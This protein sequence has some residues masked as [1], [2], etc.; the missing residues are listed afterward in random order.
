M[1]WL[2]F[3][4]RFYEAQRGEKE[5]RKQREKVRYTQ[6]ETMMSR[7]LF[8]ALLLFSVGQR[9]V[10]AGVVPSFEICEPLATSA[11]L[12]PGSCSPFQNGGDPSTFPPQTIDS[13]CKDLRALEALKCFC[14]NSVLAFFTSQ[15]GGLAP[16]Q[17]LLGEKK[18]MKKEKKK[19]GSSSKR[20]TF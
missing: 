12:Q 1:K 2:P 19:M 5:E 10:N 15:L 7:F 3:G 11:L 8:V 4:L 18:M 9:A 6:E 14:N 13:C 20:K 16:S 17:T